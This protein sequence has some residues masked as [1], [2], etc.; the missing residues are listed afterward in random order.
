MRLAQLERE[1][2]AAGFTLA[3]IRGHRIYRDAAGHTLTI[4]AHNSAKVFSRA[5]LVGIRRS[6]TR[7][8]LATMRAE[9]T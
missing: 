2:R 3:R 6:M 9:E 5:E 1:L 7:L 4:A 8:L